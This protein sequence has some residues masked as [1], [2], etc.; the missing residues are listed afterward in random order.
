M[1][2]VNKVAISLQNKG[3]ELY[4]KIQKAQASC[5]QVV[6][7]GDLFI[8]KMPRPTSVV[9]CSVFSHSRDSDLWYLVP[10]DQFSLL[11]ISDV[12]ACDI[13]FMGN[14][15]FRCAHGLWVHKDDIELSSRISQIGLKVLTEI[16]EKISALATDPISLLADDEITYDP[17]YQ[18]WV[19]ELHTSVDELR[20]FLHNEPVIGLR[21]VGAESEISSSSSLLQLAAADQEIQD[22]QI[23]L[24][25]IYQLSSSKDGMLRACSYKDGLIL[26]WLP[27]DEDAV[28]PNVIYAGHSVPWVAQGDFYCSRLI[29]WQN[30]GVELIV[31][32][33]A[34]KIAVA[35]DD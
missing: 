18:D 2:P 8:L 3:A 9:W 22:S 23:P 16:R 7:E 17:D 10:G 21:L 13:E 27:S 11:A 33:E 30:G 14:F 34:I 24:L 31:N 19:E 32:Q 4:N 15:N 26:E 6:R 25:H 1:K 5:P 20:N 29:A 28:K 35:Q 12:E